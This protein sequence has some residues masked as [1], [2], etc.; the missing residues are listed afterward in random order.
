[1]EH[2]DFVKRL[3]A[4]SKGIKGGKDAITATNPPAGRDKPEVDSKAAGADPFEAKLG[5]FGDNSISKN[6]LT[7]ARADKQFHFLGEDS[8]LENP[9]AFLRKRHG[10]DAPEHLRGKHVVTPDQLEAI[11]GTLLL[12]GQGKEGVP[13][14]EW[15][16]RSDTGFDKTA[17]AIAQAAAKGAFG[18][19][20]S[21]IQRALDVT[22]GGPLIRTDIEQVVYE[23]YLRKFPAAESV[24]KIPANGI[25]HTY[26]RRTATGDAATIDDLGDM[27]AAMVN[28]TY[29]LEQNSHIATIVSPRAIGLKLRYAVQQ[30][31]M[32][33]NL[34]GNDSLEI[35][36]GLTAIAKKNQTLVLQGNSSTAAKTLDDEEGL[37]DAKGFD[38]LRTILKGAGTSITKANADAF[39]DCINKAVGQ[40][41]NAG[42]D[43]EN[44]LVM[45]SVAV[46]FALNL[47]MQQFMRVTNKTPGGGFDTALS[48]NGLVTLGE[49]LS[50]ILS[51]PADAQGNGLGYYTFG[52]N[53][54]EDIDVI[55]PSGLALAYLGSAT[56][57][58]LELPIGFNHQLSQVYYPFLMNGLVVYIPEF[59]RKVRVPRQSI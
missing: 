58:I 38:G 18:Q 30:S 17:P 5:K 40:I 15:L 25:K 7:L 57:V 3:E 1:M 37:T 34:D 55:E 12:K 21:F 28:S 43:V 49:W 44:L 8:V 9:R 39:V 54:V 11:I 51:V 22:S 6:F 10:I 50:K 36:A 14:H 42:G 47:E 2:E 56:P 45:M 13:F 46:R 4:V 59:N 48:A 29:G 19:N 23:V 24:R 31:G 41:M 16:V 20:G 33:Y 26:N 27:S 52:G 53:V 32:T 35:M